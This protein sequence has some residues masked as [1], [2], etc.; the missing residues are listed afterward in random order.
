[1]VFHDLLSFVTSELKKWRNC[2]KSADL[3]ARLLNFWLNEWS[4][5][6]SQT[7]RRNWCGPW[8]YFRIW[9]TSSRKRRD[10]LVLDAAW[11]LEWQ[12]RRR[13]AAGYHCCSGLSRIRGSFWWSPRTSLSESASANTW[14]FIDSSLIFGG[15]SRGRAHNSSVA[16]GLRPVNSFWSDPCRSAR[17]LRYYE[18]GYPPF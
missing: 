16:V 3:S 2:S 18:L 8:S 1:M 6:C 17:S 13:P 9:K 4:G 12:N 11:K 10:D 15:L 7:S 14:E 5:I